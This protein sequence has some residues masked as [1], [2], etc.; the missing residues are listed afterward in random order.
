M[1]SPAPTRVLAPIPAD[2][3]AKIQAAVAN[4][5][6]V[7]DIVRSVVDVGVKNVIL[8][9]CGGSLFSFGPL[10]TILDRSPVPVLPYNSDELL[11]R[12]PAGLGPGSLV[13][14]SSTRGHTAETARAAAAAQLAGATVIGVTQDPNSLVAAECR[15]VLLHDGVEAKQVMLAQLGWSLLHALGAAP[16]YGEA[17][18][19]LSQTPPAFLSAVQASDPLLD[20]IA[21]ALYGEPVIYVLGSGPLE[22][23]AHTLA[24]CYL[25]EMQWKH[26]AAV[27]CG[28]F[29]HG[30]FEIVTEDLPVILLLG[31]DAT[32]P[33]GERVRRFLDRYTR[34]AHY[35]DAADLVLDGVQPEMRPFVGSLVMTSGLLARLAEHFESWTGHAL[36]DRRYMW[37]VDY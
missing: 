12:R 25:Q 30:A 27:G 23:A 5:A 16:D 29:L 21:A 35:L 14:A 6:A 2:Y 8:V 18:K 3:T 9:G 31:E 15:H 24:V 10:L 33:M 19:A 22:S 26:A 37:K 28:E 1:T 36:C 32:R 20:R 17:Q 4:G 7:D 13:V 11:L 34:K